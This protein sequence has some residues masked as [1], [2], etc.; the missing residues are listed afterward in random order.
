MSLFPAYSSTA[1][2]IS[3]VSPVKEIPKSPFMT[4]PAS[5]GSVS[6]NESAYRRLSFTIIMTLLPILFV[7]PFVLEPGRFG[8]MTNI[9][10]ASRNL[11]LI[12]G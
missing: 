5:C 4:W 12:S 9:T 10:S 7:A 6:Q 2:S 11:S 1:F 3:P 8:R